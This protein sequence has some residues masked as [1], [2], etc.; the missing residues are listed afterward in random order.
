MATLDEHFPG[1]PGIALTPPRDLVSLRASLR[2]RAPRMLR[3]ADSL[4]SA[5]RGGLSS[6][7]IPTLGIGHESIDR[8]RKLLYALSALM[9]MPSAAEPRRHRVV[10]DLKPTLQSGEYFPT[11][12]EHDGEAF[13][14]TDVQY[15]ARPERYFLLYIVEPARCGGDELMM[16]HGRSL[17]AQLMDTEQGRE[18]VRV[19]SHALLPFRVPTVFTSTGSGSDKQF[20]HAA[21]FGDDVFLRWRGDTIRRGLEENP[22]LATHEVRSAVECVE[23]LLRSAP[24][25]HRAML[26]KDSLC[27]V[28]NHVVLHGRTSFSDRE[29]HLIRIRFHGTL[30]DAAP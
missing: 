15:Y 14:H 10:W 22:A 4:L 20:T 28:D 3:L 9:G 19:L 24:G 12:S 5:L 16:R 30:G 27:V 7:T 1:V 6:V 13:Y 17:K 25:E 2:E 23:S 26:P 18:A 8:K 21:V 29:R 11:F